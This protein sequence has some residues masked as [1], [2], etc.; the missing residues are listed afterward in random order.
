VEKMTKNKTIQEPDEQTTVFVIVNLP[1]IP[2]NNHKNAK[3]DRTKPHRTSNTNQDIPYIILNADN[4]QIPKNSKKSELL[5]KDSKQKI[6]DKLTTRRILFS[7]LVALIAGYV[8]YSLFEDL[9][10]SFPLYVPMIAWLSTT[11]F[12]ISKV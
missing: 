7:Q 9:F 4:E 12:V 6:T 8:T 11:L 3:S 5:D 10:G 1:Q 2:D